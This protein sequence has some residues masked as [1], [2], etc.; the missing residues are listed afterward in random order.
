MR[1]AA[2]GWRLAAV[3]AV[4]VSL[5]ACSSG[6]PKGR[7]AGAAQT[8]PTKPPAPA[9]TA[10]TVPTLTSFTLA[11]PEIAAFGTDPLL[12]VE[13]REG[14]HA[15]LD[16][17][18]DR[19]VVTPLRSGRAGDLAPLFT[20]PALE[21]LGG[22]DRAALIDEGFGGATEISVAT[23]AAQLTA[24]VGPEGV[25]LIVAGIDLAVTAKVNG[26]PVAIHRSGELTLV[27]DGDAW[28]ITAYDVRVDRDGA[29]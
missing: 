27:V 19:A 6:S 2:R 5:T 22:S 12:P 17:Y 20:A 11:E 24:L 29:Q 18:L 7:P 13:A 26:G 21:R 1:R 4:T 16:Q 15:L 28:K 10:S 8:T 14:A 23:A 9:A 3:V 25:H